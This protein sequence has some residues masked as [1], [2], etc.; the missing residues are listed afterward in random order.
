MSFVRSGWCKYKLCV[1]S[2]L[3]LTRKAATIGDGNT[4]GFGV[5]FWR[6]HAF[7]YGFK[8]GVGTAEFCLLFRK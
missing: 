7:H 1:D 4:S 8:I 3:N 2:D 5:F 6:D